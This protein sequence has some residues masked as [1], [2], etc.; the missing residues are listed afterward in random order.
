MMVERKRS[1]LTVT[2]DDATRERLDELADEQFWSR[3]QVVDGLVRFHD[4]LREQGS[5]YEVM[6]VV[7][8]G[9]QE[10]WWRDDDGEMQ[11]VDLLTEFKDLLRRIGQGLLVQPYEP[12]DQ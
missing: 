9:E 5:R 3:S 11:E 2:I 7:G 12:E 10:I 6:T 8:T 1:P 4:I